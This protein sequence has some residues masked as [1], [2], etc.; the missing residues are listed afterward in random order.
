[1]KNRVGEIVFDG[2]QTRIPKVQ[3]LLKDPVNGKEPNHGTNPEVTAP[4]EAVI[5]GLWPH[6]EP[7]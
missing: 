1:M 3:Q 7:G 6:E 5:G 2:G 4:G